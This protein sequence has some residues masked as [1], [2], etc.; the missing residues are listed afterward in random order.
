MR[1]RDREVRGLDVG[2]AQGSSDEGVV[3]DRVEVG[4]SEVRGLDVGRG[5]SSMHKKIGRDICIALDVQTIGGFGGSYPYITPRS[6]FL[7]S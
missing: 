3:G 7:A 6:E 5:Q 1:V 4:H 2:R